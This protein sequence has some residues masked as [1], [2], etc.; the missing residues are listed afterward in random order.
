MQR[1]HELLC[2]SQEQYGEYTSRLP[3]EITPAHVAKDL[4]ETCHHHQTPSDQ[5][6]F[7]IHHQQQC[8]QSDQ[9]EENQ[10]YSM[11]DLFEHVFSMPSWSDVT[12]MAAR[13]NWD[14]NPLVATN[15]LGVDPL[16]PL[17]SGPKLFKTA[18]MPLLDE[19]VEANRLRSQSGDHPQEGS[20][21][22]HVGDG[23]QF[24]NDELLGEQQGLGI[25]A[26]PS[27][28]MGSGMLANQASLESDHAVSGL[29]S[30]LRM[31][32]DANTGSLAL[33][34]NTSPSLGGSV[35]MQLPGSGI[36]RGTTSLA[37]SRSVGTSG[38]EG[39]AGQPT[40]LEYQ[41]S[42][43]IAPSWQQPYGGG[44]GSLP[45]SL[46][47]AKAEAFVPV[48]ET[49]TNEASIFGK[50]Y[51]GEEQASA[52]DHSSSATQEAQG[53]LFNPYGGT[54]VNQ[55][56]AARTFGQP[57]HQQS[58]Q[59]IPVQAF[60]GQGTITHSQS[61]NAHTG[62]PRPRVRARRGQATDP[63]SIAERLR[64]ERI[65]DR[66][67]WLQELVPNANKTDKASMLDEIIDYVKFLQLQVKV[68]SMSRMGGAGV[69]ATFVSDLPS[70]GNSTF[71]SGNLSSGPA[72]AASSPD[73]MTEREVARLM[74]QDMGHAMQFLQS[75]GLC[76]MPIAL[77]T[78]I[79]SK[80]G[81][82]PGIQADKNR[83][84]P[85][86]ASMSV[87]SGPVTGS[88]AASPVSV[89][90]NGISSGMKTKAAGISSLKEYKENPATD[91]SSETTQSQRSPKSVAKNSEDIPRRNY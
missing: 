48:A 84:E 37:S 17:H 75:K 86:V 80:S 40:S 78:A 62:A 68:L 11:D 6:I 65:A 13:N 91:R 55:T 22:A 88:A 30:L 46:S 10:P 64:R 23:L 26:P 8:L 58:G 73:V 9:P 7:F 34:S 79:S 44:V 1:M 45:L 67:K 81:K 2:M 27:S 14:F 89:G 72:A 77:A 87:S 59:G 42:L 32:E 35:A 85:S 20:E 5:E 24:H 53:P 70:E 3:L 82:P 15:G 76:L 60:G 38:S 66:M 43:P 56:Q 31:P 61:V 74:E 54:Q 57:S 39:A 49:T 69:V 71:G 29:L 28:T 4:H 21:D 90:G 63:H 83:T 18:L 50:R 19:S 51:R 16:V 36:R 12:S 25:H 33:Q 41:S 52:R 47:Q